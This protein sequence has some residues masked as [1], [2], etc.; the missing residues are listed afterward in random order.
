MRN[1]PRALPDTSRNGQ[2]REFACQN[3][4]SHPRDTSGSAIGIQLEMLDGLPG[5]EMPQFV[6]IKTVQRRK[7]IAGEQEEDR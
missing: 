7:S 3:I 2:L 4:R 1:Q 5:V 6:A